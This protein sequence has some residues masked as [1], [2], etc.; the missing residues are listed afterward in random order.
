[1]AICFKLLRKNPISIVFL[2]YLTTYVNL[3]IRTFPIVMANQRHPKKVTDEFLLLN[4][5]Q[6]TVSTEFI[7]S[8]QEMKAELH[9]VFY[10]LEFHR[11]VQYF[12]LGLRQHTLN[13][14]FE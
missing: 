14:G 2:E 7:N 10:V 11:N 12:E 13:E 6:G 8:D 1:V 3:L 9:N 5:Y 4:L